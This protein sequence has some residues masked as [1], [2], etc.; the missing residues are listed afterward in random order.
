MRIRS[1]YGEIL[2]RAATLEPISLKFGM[3]K[4][5][6]YTYLSHFILKKKPWFL[7]DL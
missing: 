4:E 3:E 2:L 5:Y 7:W 1:L 6:L